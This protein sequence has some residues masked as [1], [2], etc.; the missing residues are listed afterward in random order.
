LGED[1]VFAPFTVDFKKVDLLAVLQPDAC[2]RAVKCDQL[3]VCIV[4]HRQAELLER[5]VVGL[6][7]R[8]D[9]VVKSIYT[10]G[11]KLQTSA[12]WLFDV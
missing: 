6:V 11:N 10:A 4:V 3:G 9:G 5:D 7:A 2:E 12:R 8:C 1:V